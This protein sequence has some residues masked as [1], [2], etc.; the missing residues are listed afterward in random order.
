MMPAFLRAATRHL[1]LFLTYGAAGVVIALV[2]AYIAWSVRGRPDLEIWHRT[3]LA[4]EFRASDA[5][6]VGDFAGYLRLEDRLFKELRR[7]VYDRVPRSERKRL[8]RYSAG[9]LADPGARPV[10]W[11]R[12]YEI[13]VASP[14]AAALLVHGLTDSPYLMRGI[15]QR[16]H[17]QGVWVVGLRL[18][19]HGTVPEALTQVQWEDWAAAVRLAARHLRARAGPKVP[20][21]LVGFSTGAALSVEYSLSRLRGEDLPEASGLVLLSPAIGVDPLAPVS[22]WQLRLAAIPGL[23]KLAWLSIGPEYDPYKYVS[24]ATN[25]GYQ[26]YR[27]TRRIGEEMDGI[28]GTAPL[29]RFPRTLVFQSVADATVSTPAVVKAFL[30]RLAPEGHEL[31]AFDVNRRAEVEPLLKPGGRLPAEKLLSGPPL[32]FDYTLFTNAGPDSGSMVARRRAAGSSEVRE[33]ATGLEWPAGIYSLSHLALPI[34]PDDPVYGAQ[35]PK[36][37]TMIYLGR[38]GLQGE[39]GLLA[40]PATSLLRIRFNPFFPY[41]E[42]RILSFLAPATRTREGGGRCGARALIPGEIAPVAI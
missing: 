2:G 34:P 1:L 24:F 15:A 8:N 5:T 7:E 3:H 14:R 10:D 11:S 27:L 4:E 37:P 28:A 9:S 38:L 32:P 36:E 39:D 42:R 21:Y 16:L 31:V 19:G 6:R 41:L 20:L 18:P 22:L 40:I 23:G 33:E 13:P 17:D 29:R 25:A 12:S 35:R 26:I 30:G